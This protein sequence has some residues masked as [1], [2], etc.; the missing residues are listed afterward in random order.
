MFPK[1]FVKEVP[2][3][4]PPGPKITHRIS[5]IDL[6]KVLK[7]PTCK[8][9][10]ALMTKYKAWINK[11]MNTGILHRTSVPGGASMFVEAKSNGRIPQLVDLRFR[12]DNPQADHTQIPE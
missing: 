5:R 6:T 7:T 11:Q 2:V 8:T 10:Q 3:E 12:N 4:L 1:V 9:L